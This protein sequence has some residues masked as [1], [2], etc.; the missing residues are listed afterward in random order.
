M[1]VNWLLRLWRGCDHI[2]KDKHEK[3]NS[4]KGFAVYRSTHITVDSVEDKVVDGP[5]LKRKK[6]PGII[7]KVDRCGCP[8]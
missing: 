4:D 1:I 3:N 8:K 5:D 2:I 7:N 6:P